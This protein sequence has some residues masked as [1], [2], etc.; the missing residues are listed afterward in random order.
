M[1]WRAISG[2]DTTEDR[3]SVKALRRIKIRI[4]IISLH[5]L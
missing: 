2:I 3:K 1:T 4:I 5:I